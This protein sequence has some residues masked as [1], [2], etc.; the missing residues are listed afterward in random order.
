MK[1]ILKIVDKISS[2][3]YVGE[4]STKKTYKIESTVPVRKGQTVLASGGR[5]TGVIRA[6]TLTV[7]N[8]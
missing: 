5:I 6:E 1:Q 7:Y 3:Q 4:D 8:V 2:I